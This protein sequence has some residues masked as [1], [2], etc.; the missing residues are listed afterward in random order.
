MPNAERHKVVVVLL[1]EVGKLRELVG[2]REGGG[3]DDGVGGVGDG[4][5]GGEDGVDRIGFLFVRRRGLV[6][7]WNGEGK[8]GRRTCNFLLAT[9]STSVFVSL[10]T[11]VSV[12]KNLYS[13]PSSTLIT[14]NF[15]S[16]PFTALVNAIAPPRVATVLSTPEGVPWMTFSERNDQALTVFEWAGSIVEVF[17]GEGEDGRGRIPCV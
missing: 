9:P 1:Y 5:D 17:E 7:E 8:R 10:G 16:L 15:P 13:F 6:G 3:E 11:F 12:N 4:L 2:S 14:S